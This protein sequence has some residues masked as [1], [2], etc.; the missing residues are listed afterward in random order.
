MSIILGTIAAIAT[1]AVSVTKSLAVVGLAVQGLKTL[2][3]SLMVVAKVLGLIKPEN[4]IEELGDKAL[5]AEEDGIKLENYK[6]YA[7]YVKAVEEY[8]VDVEKSELI[9]EERK[10]LKGIELTTGVII[11]KFPELPIVDFFEYAGKNPEYFTEDRMKEIGNL[12]KDN[13]KY[14]SD[15][16][17]YMNGSEKDDFILGTTIDTLTSIEKKVNPEI[18][19]K[20]AL[21]YVLNIRK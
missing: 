20:D 5:Q 12:M 1:A 14:V 11:E 4:K 18:S 17:N 19:N 16:L 8:D 6:S 13:G 21:K 15:I 7:E 9:P 2:G 10:I 3:N